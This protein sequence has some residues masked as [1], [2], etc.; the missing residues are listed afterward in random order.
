VELVDAEEV[1]DND[2]ELVELEAARAY[3]GV[4]VGAGA[5][6]TGG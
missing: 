3:I 5:R 4:D 1:D 2:V 6:F